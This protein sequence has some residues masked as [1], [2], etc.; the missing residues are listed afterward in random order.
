MTVR[1][2]PEVASLEYPGPPAVAGGAAKALGPAG[3]GQVVQAGGVIRESLLEVH[4]AAREV[5]P[6][7]MTTVGTQ[8]DGTG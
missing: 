2:L 6:A 1:A 8:P 5:W 4:D 7:H 3:V